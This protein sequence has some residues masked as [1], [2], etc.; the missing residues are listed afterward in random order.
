MK[1]FVNLLLAFLLIFALVGCSNDTSD[2]VVEE[3]T[4]DGYKIAVVTDIGL[5]ND[6]GFNQGTYG[7]AVAFAEDNGFTHKYYQPT[8]S[9]EATDEERIA[10]MKQAIE[11]GCEILITPGSLQAN[12][13]SVVAQEYPDIKFVFVDGWNMGFDNLTAIS[14]QE[15]QS[16]F[17]AG[18][19]AV[20]DG[21]TKLGGTFG[22]A[23][24]NG[25]S[26]RFA[27]G[28]L[29]GIEAAAA[30]LEETCDVTI[31]FKYGAGFSASDELQAQISDWY[32][33]GTEIVF[34]CGGRMLQSVIAA[35]EKTENGM[36]IGVDVDQAGESERILT[37]AVKG[38]RASV[39]KVLTEWNKGE[40]DLKLKDQTSILGVTDDAVGLPTGIG[41]WRFNS[42]SI[43]D[44]NELLANV[45]NG[46]ITISNETNDDM[47]TADAWA[48]I[49]SKCSH[50]NLTIE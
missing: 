27:L 40:W 1:K 4:E 31:S 24:T 46:S 20:K 10:A 18:Y 36:I 6:G 35:A 43:D 17:F 33:N 37:S 42:F 2:E 30:E 8:S 5:L 34:S 15:E 32:S 23:G 29:Q 25:A 39:Y 38:L 12:A 19:A 3:P 44:Y 7:G 47:S 21:Y 11:N 49:A 50:V 14:Y 41:S 48:D 26:N 28:Y 45:A 22:G 13:L 16:G 9:N